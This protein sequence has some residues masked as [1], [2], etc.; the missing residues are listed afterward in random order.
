MLTHG[1]KRKRGSD[2]GLGELGKVTHDLVVRHATGQVFDT[3]YTV[4]RVPTEAR[5]A[6]ADL[7][8]NVDECRQI[9]DPERTWPALRQ[10]VERV[11]S[12]IAARS[13]L[14]VPTNTSNLVLLCS[15]HHHRLHQPGWN[16]FEVTDPNG[17]VRST[18]PPRAEPGW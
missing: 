12:E 11:G 4:M 16:A 10:A 1:S 9:H 8:P 18:S 7:G 6:A 15:R 14:G 3:S 13:A 5:L 2:V 17:Q